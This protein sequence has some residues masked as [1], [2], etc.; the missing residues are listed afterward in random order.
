MTVLPAPRYWREI[1]TSGQS[2]PAMPARTSSWSSPTQWALALVAAPLF[3]IVVEFLRGAM[4]ETDRAT[5]Q[6]LRDEIQTLQ[7]KAV[8][9][10][11]GLQTLVEAHKASDLSWP[12]V[13][14]QTW[15]TD[16]WSRIR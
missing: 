16:Y 1:R 3:L 7:T 12:E 13:R 4:H 5:K 14:K 2:E 15:F 11:E 8:Q 6:T 10:A 9:Y